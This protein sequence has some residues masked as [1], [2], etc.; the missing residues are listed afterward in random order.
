MNPDAGEGPAQLHG[1]KQNKNKIKK[2]LPATGDGEVTT[3]VKAAEPGAHLRT[4]GTP[5]LPGFIMG[6]DPNQKKKENR[7]K[8]EKKDGSQHGCCSR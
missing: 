8:K 1:G 4:K 3:T 6:S 2:D 7:K 5:P